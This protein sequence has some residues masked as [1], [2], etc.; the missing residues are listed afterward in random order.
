MKLSEMVLNVTLIGGP[1]DGECVRF[2]CSDN[3]PPF[4][5]HGGLWYEHREAPRKGDDEVMDWLE[6]VYTFVGFPRGRTT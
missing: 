6:D 2:M 5:L 3:F 1:E 4:L